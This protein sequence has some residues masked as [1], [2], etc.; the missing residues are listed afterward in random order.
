MI[1]KEAAYVITI[2][3]FIRNKQKTL[4]FVGQGVSIYYVVVF[5]FFKV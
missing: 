3:H 5:V 2:R 1:H 4:F